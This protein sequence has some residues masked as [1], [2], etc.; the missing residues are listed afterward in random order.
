MAIAT[1]V[2]TTDAPPVDGSRPAR[3]KRP[4]SLAPKGPNR[5]LKLDFWVDTF[6][7]GGFLAAQSFR[8]TGINI[9]EWVGVAMGIALIAHITLH[10][11]W[12]VRT[13]TRLVAKKPGRDTLRWAND[14]LVMGAM[15][16]TVASGILSSRVVLP[17]FGIGAGSSDFW[18]EVHFKMAYFSLFLIGLHVALNW[19]WIFTFL[20]RTMAHRRYK[21]ANTAEEVAA[22]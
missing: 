12:V 3:T 2:G 1:L 19:R 13:T 5:A 4:K 16:L 22:R 10:W 8:L 20:K 7:L 11:E 9:H 14:L 21:Q 6:L 17:L 15:T 18:L